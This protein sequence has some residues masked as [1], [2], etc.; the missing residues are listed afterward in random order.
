VEKNDGPVEK[1]KEREESDDEEKESEVE[2][3]AELL[4]SFVPVSNIFPF[5]FWFKRSQA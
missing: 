1:T 2:L 5:S 4:I 3:L